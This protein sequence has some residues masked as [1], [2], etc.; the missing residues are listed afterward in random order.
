MTTQIVFNIDRKIK[1]RA[2]ERAKREGIPFASVLKLAA[3]AFAEGRLS[4]DVIDAID[5][6][7][8]KML[9][10]HSRL[11]DVGKGR[12]LGTMKAFR[13]YIRSL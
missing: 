1:A 13:S 12:R 8:M 10:R 3:K 6:R 2:M 7:R 4:V 9:E 11:L 5:P